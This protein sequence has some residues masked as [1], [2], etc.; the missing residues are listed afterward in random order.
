MV[1]KSTAVA[2][3]HR[4]RESRVIVMKTVWIATKAINGR[5]FHPCSTRDRSAAARSRVAAASARFCTSCPRCTQRRTESRSSR[6]RDSPFGHR[7]RTTQTEIDPANP[8]MTNPAAVARSSSDRVSPP[9]G[10][11]PRAVVAA[12]SPPSTSP[13]EIA[14]SSRERKDQTTLVSQ[15]IGVTTEIVPRLPARGNDFPDDAPYQRATI[16][17]QVP[18]VARLASADGTSVMGISREISGAIR[19]AA[20]RRMSSACVS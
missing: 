13:A 19:P 17:P 1:T 4:P 7:P 9:G 3:S 10:I 15:Y 12:N 5:R 20:C 16:F 2:P 8:P 14:A 6:L 11:R 18:R